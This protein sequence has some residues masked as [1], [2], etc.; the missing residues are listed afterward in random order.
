[1]R[2]GAPHQVWSGLRAS[3]VLVSVCCRDLGGGSCMMLCSCRIFSTCS[4]LLSSNLCSSVVLSLCCMS[5]VVVFSQFGMGSVFEM[6]HSLGVKSWSGGFCTT[7]SCM[8][9][10]M[11]RPMVTMCE[12]NWL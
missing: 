3:L 2:G 4:F 9:V 10:C 11:L 12:S 5:S 8:M 6:V 7:L 1:M